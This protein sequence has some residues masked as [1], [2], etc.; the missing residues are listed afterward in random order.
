M[1]RTFRSVLRM[2]PRTDEPGPAEA[3][4]GH[5]AP[6]KLMARTPAAATAMSRLLFAAAALLVS[7]C[8]AAAPAPAPAA[9]GPL[10]C[11]GPC[12]VLLDDSPGEAWEPHAAIDPNDGRHV[13][14]A[15]RTVE[16]GERPGTF[17]AWFN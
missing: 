3:P 14:V 5:E 11:P 9:H 4:V 12:K 2:S 6:H 17:S 13:A 15:S 8:L 1:T 7:G 10:A 16:S